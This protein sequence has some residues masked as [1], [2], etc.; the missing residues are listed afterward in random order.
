MKIHN[1][2]VHKLNKERQEKSTIIEKPGNEL[3]EINDDLLV[4][5][6]SLRK[7]YSSKTGRGYGEFIDDSD[8][9]P[10]RSRL[11]ECLAGNIDFLTFT[12]KAMLILKS[13]IDDVRLATGGYM[14]FVDYTDDQSHSMIVASIKDRK[15]LAFDEAL[16][17]TGAMHLELDRLHEMAKVDLSQWKAGEEKYLSFAKSRASS[18]DH[19]EYFQ[20]FIGCEELANAKTMNELLVAA[21]RDYAKSNQMDPDQ[22]KNLRATVLNY[23]QEKL[24]SND[25]IDLVML[26]QRVNE[27]QPESFV[28]FVNENQNKY[29]ISNH[30]DPVRDVFK[31]LKILKMKRGDVQVQFGV[32]SLGQS[33]TLNNQDCLVISDLDI[34]FINQIREIQ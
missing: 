13:K 6:N 25:K 4:L 31:K 7:L 5:V 20:N 22:H 15:G 9:Y 30:F 8:N 12:K 2:I 14:L 3:L 11:D 19:S 29:P 23:C 28:S 26:S 1:A 33:V 18:N 17:L 24:D 27:D 16:N 10:F 32:E 21:V 34:K